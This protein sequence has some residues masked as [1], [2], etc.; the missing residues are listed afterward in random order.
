MLYLTAMSTN[1]DNI[2]YTVVTEWGF[3]HEGG[4]LTVERQ[5]DCEIWSFASLLA[6]VED[7]HV[8]ASTTVDLEPPEV[9][10]LINT[11]LAAVPGAPCGVCKGANVLIEDGL[12]VV[13]VDCS[14]AQLVLEADNEPDWERDD[15]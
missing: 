7:T 14:A 3:A 11:L 15:D 1:K 2:V 5:Y 10:L 9:A 4:K 6:E 12:A 8:S 13:C